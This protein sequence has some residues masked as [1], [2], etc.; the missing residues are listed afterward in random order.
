M[1]TIVAIALTLALFGC[2][3]VTS[4]YD[5]IEEA[6]ADGLFDR[7]WLPDV[8]PDSANSIRAKNQ[9]DTNWSEGEFSFLPSDADKL[10]D[11]LSE[12]APPVS[13]LG[14]WDETVSRYTSRGYSAWSYH[15]EES[16]WAFF[17]QGPLGR[18]EYIM[19]LR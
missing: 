6:R 1:R 12:G 13:R 16:T 4:R 2:D 8:L 17:C 5:T 18:C 11:K 15:D 10:F 3:S 7:G 9:L 14:D 19:W